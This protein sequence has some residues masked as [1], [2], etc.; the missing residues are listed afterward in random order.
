MKDFFK[1]FFSIAGLAAAF[2]VG[3]NYG[4][5]SF[6]ESEEYK[7]IAL[8]RD[9]LDF[10]RSDIENAKIK[11][12]NIVDRADTR[13]TDEILG[14]I[15]Q[16]FLADLGIQIRNKELIIK[17][18]EI[19][20]QALAQSAKTTE[21]NTTKTAENKNIKSD[22]STADDLGARAIAELKREQ[23]AEA[24]KLKRSLG[25][26][27]SNEFLVSNSSGGKDTL[28]GLDKVIIRNLNAFL[29]QT[30][31]DQQNCEK[32]LGEYKG[33]IK[34]VTNQ[35]MG[36]LSFS[37]KAA[38]SGEKIEFKNLRGEVSWFNAPN[39]PM[40]QKINESCGRRARDLSGR[41]F[42]LTD[43]RYIQ[44]YQIDGSNK[45]AGNFYEVMP[46]GTTKRIGKF[47]LNRTDRF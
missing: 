25:Q 12:Q 34:D 39:P 13:K 36:S 38:D 45:L 47:V 17:Q 7:K 4:E 40:S 6:M 35:N 1:I 9:E 10:A 15:L 27:K 30:F 41:I 31:P 2:A 18:A 29:S 23:E 22:E 32:F 26:F 11:L 20:T 21:I 33:N 42:S 46:N 28:R 19:C 44:I 16:V 14:Q 3:K 8:T 37:L 24:L 5:K 43:N